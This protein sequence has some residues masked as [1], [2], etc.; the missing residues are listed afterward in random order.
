[1]AA[2][3]RWD[4]SILALLG[5]SVVIKILLIPSYT[6][7]DFEV[8][9]NWLAITHTLPKAQWYHEATSEWTLDYP[10]FFA[11]FEYALSYVAAKVNPQ[12][13]AISATPIFSDRIRLFQRLS[14]IVSDSVLFHAIN[15]YCASWPS[16][17]TTEMG[18]TAQK[19]WAIML[20]TVL[21]AG[22]LYVDHI[23]FQ[24]NGMLLG[25]LILS[26]TKFRQKKDLQGAALYAALLMFKHIYLYVAPLYFVYLLGHH[27]YTSATKT[28]PPRRRS[29]S[30]IDEHETIQNFQDGNY[31]FSLT[32][33]IR[34]GLLVLFVFGVAFGSVLLHHPDKVAG[35]MQIASRLFPIQRGLC[36][37]YW[38]P[39]VWAL[40]AFLDKVLVVVFGLGGNTAGMAL[41]SGGLVQEASFAVLP[42]VPPLVCALATFVTMVPVLHTVWKYPDSSL[43]MSALIYCMMCSFM[44]G[45]HVHEKAIL[46]VVLPLGLMAADSVHDMRLYRFASIVSNVSLFPLLFT[47]AEQPTKV[48]LAI[49]HGVVAYVAL[50]PL[51]KTSLKTRH[52]KATAV[53]MHV[54]EK[55]FLVAL[56]ACVVVAMAF[57]LIPRFGEKYAFL[58]LMLFSVSCAVGNVYVWGTSLYLHFRKL[59]AV[60]SYLHGPKAQ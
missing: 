24:Y 51:L 6:S 31:A 52:I 45:Y 15:E 37:A 19:R 57:P 12:L 40:Y 35:L 54:L 27:C 43:F 44:L 41:M 48:L 39:N 10:P 2:R 3:T 23:H 4:A 20:L 18:Y 55:L 14:V 47:V 26:A 36:H 25:L 42:A 34:L 59:A 49:I 28:P 29:I 56:V 16:V 30:D 13:V 33:F 5:V 53:R 46:Q 21:D 8:H 60:K 32:R 38:A 1:M 17:T 22:L 50:D 11:Y 9:R 7:T 58:P